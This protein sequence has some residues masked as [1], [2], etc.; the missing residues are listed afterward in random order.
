MSFVSSGTGD[1]LGVTPAAGATYQTLVAGT[2]P[3]PYST[4]GLH[5][6]STNHVP[7][8][9]LFGLNGT[10]SFDRAPALN[11]LTL[12]VQISNILDKQ[13]PF[14][15]G[16]T[17]FGPSNLYGGTNPIFFDTAGRAFRAGFRM[18]F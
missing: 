6:L 2:L 12:F 1:Y 18:S 14:A 9:V 13:P 15:N 16:G 10:Y 4:Y 7:S 17:A 5:P 8:Y 11:G 3:Y